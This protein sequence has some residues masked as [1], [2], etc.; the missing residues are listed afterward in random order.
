MLMS[1]R[2][3][4]ELEYKMRDEYHTKYQWQ[5]LGRE[6]KEDAKGIWGHKLNQELY[7]KTIRQTIEV[8]TFP[9]EYVP[10]N[11]VFGDEYK[12]Y[13]ITETIEKEKTS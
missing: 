11:F 8:K 12:Y 1:R 7:M 5:E 10:H 9:R 2:D 6:I 13:H 4:E 3:A